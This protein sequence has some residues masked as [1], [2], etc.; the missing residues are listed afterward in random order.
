MP[1]SI[2]W[3]TLL[4]ITCILSGAGLQLCTKFLFETSTATGQPFTKPFSL[5]ILV[6]AAMSTSL[7]FWLVRRA[8]N[9]CC[10]QNKSRTNYKQPLLSPSADMDIPIVSA[11]NSCRKRWVIVPLALSDMCV[12]VCDLVSIMLCPASILGVVNC[13]I[14]VLS[15]ITTRVILGTRR[16]LRQ[17]LGIGIAT[18]GI[19]VVGSVAVIEDG[20]LARKGNATTP[21][22][23]TTHRSGNG[24]TWGATSGCAIA[25][26]ARLLQSW[27]FALEEKFMKNG[28]FDPLLQVSQHTECMAL[29]SRSVHSHIKRSTT[30]NTQVGLEGAIEMLLVGGV[31]LPTVATLPGADKSVQSVHVCEVHAGMLLAHVRVRVDVYFRHFLL[32]GHPPTRG[33][34]ASGHVEDVLGALSA[35]AQTPLLAALCAVTYATLAAMNPLSM[36]IGKHGNPQ[37]PCTSP[38]PSTPVH[39]P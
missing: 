7:L 28:L 18:I 3:L 37:P 34:F 6:S 36:A 29:C 14:L 10:H 17:W 27:Q 2:G 24:V 19:L 25:L 38:S 35:V 33:A 32:P 16:G 13:S 39:T 15:A 21:T 12:T 31:L 20:F 9:G 30:C 8:M 4:C 23:A 5:C 22:N 1:M 11:A 26:A